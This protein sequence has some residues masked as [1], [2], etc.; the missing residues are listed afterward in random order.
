MGLLGGPFLVL[1]SNLGEAAR[2]DLDHKGACG[3]LQYHSLLDMNGTTDTN[4]YNRWGLLTEGGFPMRRHKMSNRSSKR[5]FTKHAMR[6]HPK[7]TPAMP[8][9]GGI[10]L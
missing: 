7:N 5:H 9:R 6:S 3:W 1:P 2:G 4:V 8:M 10:R